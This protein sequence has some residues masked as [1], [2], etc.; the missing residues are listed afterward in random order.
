MTRTGTLLLSVAAISLSGC[1]IMQPFGH[2]SDV[3]TRP[4]HCTGQRFDIYFDEA[5]ARLTESA[6]EAIGLTA[7]RLQDCDIQTVR[8][9][10]LASGTGDSAS[11]QILSQERAA[12]V[13]DALAAAGWP[14]PAFE[15][16]ADGDAGAVT[17][18]G[19]S[20]PLRR[21]TEVLV[22]AVPRP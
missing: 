11:N 13:R 4:V 5:Q 14:A 12:T 10:G 16:E 21:R 3:V 20:Q 18:D 8:V 19:V 17:A 7:A 1:V 15:L 6:R 9:V 2:R 22:E